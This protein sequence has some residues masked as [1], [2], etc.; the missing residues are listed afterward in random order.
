MVVL[1]YGS[2]SCLMLQLHA[3]WKHV[4]AEKVIHPGT[5]QLGGAGM[6]SMIGGG[7]PLAPSLTRSSVPPTMPITGDWTGVPLR[8]RS[9]SEVLLAREN[10]FCGGAGAFLRLRGGEAPES[11]CSSDL[12]ELADFG[13][14]SE[15]DC[16]TSRSD[17]WR[18]GSRE[19]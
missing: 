6:T 10:F 16:D 18:T 13:R 15:A 5:G 8:L 17:D 14:S 9:E 2:C 19:V 3:T 4:H 7:T 11:E 1:S 12:D